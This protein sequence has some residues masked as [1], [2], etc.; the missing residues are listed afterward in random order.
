MTSKPKLPTKLDYDE[1]IEE[2]EESM[3][4]DD[5]NDDPDWGKNTQTPEVWK[6]N[7]GRNKKNPKRKTFG[8]GKNSS[9]DSLVKTLLKLLKL[10]TL[11]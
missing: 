2:S 10:T 3:L 9:S 7:Y 11:S 5:E 1:D 4:E 8:R 6:K